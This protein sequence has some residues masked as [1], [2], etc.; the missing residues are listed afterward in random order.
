MQNNGEKAEWQKLT[1]LGRKLSKSWLYR[2][3]EIRSLAQ[4]ERDLESAAKRMRNIREELAAEHAETP[5]SQII[6][7]M[8]V[9][10]KRKL[11]G[12]EEQVRKVSDLCKR[13]K[14]GDTP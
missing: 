12:V 11:D 9:D 2:E 5:P 4:A 1:D 6:G 8:L 10:K 3:K 7:P 14:R 13:A